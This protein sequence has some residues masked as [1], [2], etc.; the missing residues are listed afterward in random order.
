MN[1][2]K[3]RIVV[4]AWGKEHVDLLL[5]NALSALLSENN[6]PLLAKKF[7]CTLVVVTEKVFF[8]YVM[9]HH[10]S[11]KLQEICEIKL[12]EIDDLITEKWQYGITLTKA[13]FRGFSDLSE[14]AKEHYILFLNADF[15]LADGSYKNLIPYMESGVSVIYSPS[16]CVI[17]EQVNPILNKIATMNDGV[18]SINRRD[19]ASI[20]LANPHPT[21]KGKIVNQEKYHF[22]FQDQFYWQVD[23]NTLIGFQFPVAVVAMKPEIMLNEPNTFW[24]WGLIEEFCPSENYICLGDS[25]EFLMMELRQKR[26][27]LESLFLGKNTAKNWAKNAQLFITH[28]QLKGLG[29]PLSLHSNDLKDNIQEYSLLLKKKIDIFIRAIKKIPSHQFH[30]QWTTHENYFN[31]FKNNIQIK[32]ETIKQ[33]FFVKKNLLF[34]TK[35]KLR[36]SF[37]KL[38]LISECQEKVIPWQALS[39]F[40]RELI[41]LLSNR[42]IENILVI[43]S[44]HIYGVQISNFIE[45]NIDNN[46]RVIIKNSSFDESNLSFGHNDLIVLMLDY[47]DYIDLE[48]YMETMQYNLSSQGNLILLIIQSHVGFR[49]WSNNILARFYLFFGSNIIRAHTGGK[50]ILT[51]VIINLILIQKNIEL[52][53]PSFTFKKYIFNFF[54]EFILIPILF[55]LNF[56]DYLLPKSRDG[57]NLTILLKKI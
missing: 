17:E 23:Q 37:Y 30:E 1:S 54:L 52:R 47:R 55:I 22:K 13:L 43:S 18:I 41:N 57:S 7:Q 27:H 26:F 32:S 8:S 28:Y 31:S 40:K 33:K 4:F 19:M 14:N 38:K 39:F 45:K 5:N 25:D 20:I 46:L 51:S 21:I 36:E 9:S 53:S 49:F 50:F 2:A 6:L 3:V 15:I 12:F 34:L 35:N 29:Y 44:N 56:I 24:D 42:N 16:Y 48:S 10:I 11:K